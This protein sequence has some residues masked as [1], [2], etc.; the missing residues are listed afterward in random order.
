MYM[1]IYRHMCVIFARAGF[2]CSS[3]EFTHATQDPAEQEASGLDG[4]KT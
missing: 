3:R 1:H 4:Q 2:I